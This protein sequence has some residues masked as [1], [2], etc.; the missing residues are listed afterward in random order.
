MIPAPRKRLTTAALLVWITLFVGIRAGVG[1]EE[2]ELTS[3]ETKAAQEV[4]RHFV[5]RMQQTRNV[6]TLLDELFLPGFVSHFTSEEGIV[7]ALFSR[8][9]RSERQ[10]LFTVMFDINYLS[11]GDDHKRP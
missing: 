6:A 1:Q 9:T 5:G 7:P 3:Q 11:A 10:R 4:A 8:L 2:Q